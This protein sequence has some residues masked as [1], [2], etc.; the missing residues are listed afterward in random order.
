MGTDVAPSIYVA[1]VVVFV[2]GLCIR[3]LCLG[4]RYCEGRGRMYMCLDCAVGTVL[5]HIH[6][7]IHILYCNCTLLYIPGSDRTAVPRPQYCI[8]LL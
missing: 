3:Y 2:H 4:C 5:L 6:I 7:H 8:L 1:N